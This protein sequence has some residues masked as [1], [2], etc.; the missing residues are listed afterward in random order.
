MGKKLEMVTPKYLFYLVR[1]TNSWL[2]HHNVACVQTPPPSP[3]EKSVCTQA[4]TT[5]RGA[6]TWAH[7]SPSPP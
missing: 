6:T 7:T 1:L 3:Q 2:V 4:T 5:A